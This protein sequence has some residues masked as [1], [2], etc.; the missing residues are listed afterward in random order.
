MLL[1]KNVFNQY[2][3]MQ[4]TEAPRGN[5]LLLLFCDSNITKVDCDNITPTAI[6]YFPSFLMIFSQFVFWSVANHLVS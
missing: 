2:M 3:H 6:F 1:A 4:F 5:A